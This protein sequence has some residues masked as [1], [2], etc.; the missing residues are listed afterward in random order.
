MN[1]N[2]PSPQG[3]AA[4][5]GRTW[6]IYLAIL[7]A[8]AAVYG[9]TAQRGVSWQ[10]SGLH[11]LR[12][13]NAEYT[14]PLGLALAHPLLIAMGQP[15]RL[16]GDSSVPTALN[17]LSGVGMA[18]AIA[19]I[20]LLGRRLTGRHVPAILAAIMLGVS[21]TAWWLATIT[22]TYCW[23][24]A[25]L[26]TELVLVHSLIA[27]PRWRTAAALG[28]VNGLGL[29]LHNFALLALGVYLVVILALIPKRRLSIGAA[30]AAAVGWLIGAAGLLGLVIAQAAQTGEWG[31]AVL[32]A[33]FGRQWRED[34]LAIS[35]AAPIRALAYIFLNWPFVSLVPVV[36][37]W[38][39]IARHAAR[40]VAATFG[41]VAAIHLIFAIRYPVPDQFMF[42][43][44]AYTLLAV[45]AAVGLDA[46][47]RMQR[48][49]REI[50]ICAV[51][52]SIVLTPIAYGVAPP[53]LDRMGYSIRPGR[54]WPYRDENRYWLTP[55]KLNE[56]SAQQFAAAAL[57]VAADD[58]RIIP[59]GMATPPLQALQ[60][61][62]GCRPDVHVLPLG[63]RPATLAETAA[64]LRSYLSANPVYTVA[65]EPV[66]I[67][68]AWRP[69]VVLRR[70]GPLLR[71]RPSTE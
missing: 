48:R 32:S 46:M 25:G 59:A 69:H 29:S 71:I 66:P 35:A 12:V 53:L 2:E 55:W 57:A 5:N 65:A 39:R 56:R 22:E 26:T 42:L 33:L 67:P 43:L 11:Q 50:W 6:R 24:A 28:L 37:G 1:A 31:E 16:L 52:I 58:A 68:A 45:G 8:A 41:A 14:N 49:W 60:R 38:W 51:A 63:T 20:Y 61:A 10:D 23:V 13:L 3:G 9:L 27:R 70:I 30:V 18:I 7:L 36:L 21:H 17:V 62:T 15:L 47:F 34:V 40:P 19:N 54:S 4:S 44:P 64:E